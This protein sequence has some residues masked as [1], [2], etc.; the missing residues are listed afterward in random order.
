MFDIPMVLLK[1]SPAA[2]TM[3]SEPFATVRR[4]SSRAH[5]LPALGVERVAV[6]LVRALR[7]AA[8]ASVGDD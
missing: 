4:V 1:M 8:R 7:D 5:D 2:E 3:L 6:E